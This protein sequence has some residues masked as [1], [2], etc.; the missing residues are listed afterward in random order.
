MRSRAGLIYLHSTERDAG[1]FTG[2]VAPHRNLEP[3]NAAV[4]FTVSA[5]FT[6]TYNNKPVLWCYIFINKAANKIPKL[7]IAT[8]NQGFVQKAMTR[9]LDRQL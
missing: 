1:G 2:K 4:P 6:R 5:Y 8:L 9:R 7:F 3:L